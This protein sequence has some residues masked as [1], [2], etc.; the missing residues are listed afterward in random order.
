MAMICLLTQQVA[1]LMPE[2]ISHN[3]LNTTR[4]NLQQHLMGV[5]SDD[6]KRDNKSALF[7]AMDNLRCVRNPLVRAK[8]RGHL[9]VFYCCFLVFT[10]IFV[11]ARA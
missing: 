10:A 7:G 6:L 3:I 2:N 11:V 9:D 1:E 5:S 8:G 4:I